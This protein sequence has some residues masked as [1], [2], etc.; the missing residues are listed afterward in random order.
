[1][2]IEQRNLS[3]EQIN[4]YLN[5]YGIVSNLIGSSTFNKKCGLVIKGLEELNKDFSKRL[6]LLRDELKEEFV[7]RNTDE[8]SEFPWYGNQEDLNEMSKVERRIVSDFNKEFA[9]K[10]DDLLKEVTED[11]DVLLLT[12]SDITEQEKAGKKYKESGFATTPN[13]YRL[14]AD[15]ISE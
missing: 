6:D 2:K 11:V 4:E 13:F 14:L 9:D 7:K 3:F 8:I 5:G 12:E 10:R 15:V 1:M